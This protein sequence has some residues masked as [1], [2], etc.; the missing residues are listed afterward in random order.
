MPK[1]I[2][3][4]LL[5]ALGFAAWAADKS[6][7]KSADKPTA[8][9]SEADWKASLTA[10]QFRVLRKEGTE[11]AFTGTY[12]NDKRPGTFHC[13]GCGHAL[14][15]ANTKFKSGTG[16]PSFWQPLKTDAVGVKVDK[17]FWGVRTE[18]HCAAC[19]GHLGHVFDDGPK[20]TGKRYCINSVSLI[21][22]ADKK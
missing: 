5:I 17:K 2:L 11:R 4:I 19:G 6:E 13:S 10:E 3:T 20:P 15:G 8:Q 1:F 9:K 22:S 12:W 16:W 7:S 21:H 18:V 14:F